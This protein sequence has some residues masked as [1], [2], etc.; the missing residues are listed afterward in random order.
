MKEEPSRAARDYADGGGPKC[1]P[2]VRTGP[3]GD[4]GAR[5]AE[6]PADPLPQAAGRCRWAKRLDEL[7]SQEGGTFA[8]ALGTAGPVGQVWIV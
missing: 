3:S 8:A 2:A 4:P 7:S 1:F 6:S 5:V